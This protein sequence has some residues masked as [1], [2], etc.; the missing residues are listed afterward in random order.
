MKKFWMILAALL[1]VCAPVLADTTAV[2]FMTEATTKGQIIYYGSFE[3]VDSTANSTYYTQ[4]M[5][6]GGCNENNAYGYFVCSEAGTEDINVFVEYSRDLIT[7]D[8][9]T[10]NSAL[11]AVGTTGKFDTLNIVAGA[12][13]LE[14]WVLPWMRLKLV[15]GQNMNTPIF[16]WTVTLTKP[17]GLKQTPMAKKTIAVS[18]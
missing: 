11:D 6:V 7:W 4:A 12:K 8:A 3:V 15:V 14:Y 1:L 9:G 16:Y 10:T 5:W 13:D 18:N 17:E 2:S